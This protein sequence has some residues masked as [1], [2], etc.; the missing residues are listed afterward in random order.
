MSL[1][2]TLSAAPDEL[3][4]RTLTIELDAAAGSVGL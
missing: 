3:A 4:G 1:G 2:L